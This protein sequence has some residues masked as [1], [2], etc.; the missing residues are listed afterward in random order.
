MVS[1]FITFCAWGSTLF[2]VLGGLAL[3]IHTDKQWLGLAWIFWA[4]ANISVFLH[5]K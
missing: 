3:L 1:F 5:G 4:A 2:Y